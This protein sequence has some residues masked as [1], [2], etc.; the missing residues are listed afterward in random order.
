MEN[1]MCFRCDK[2]GQIIYFQKT[3]LPS[4]RYLWDATNN[5]LTSHP[6]DILQNHDISKTSSMKLLAHVL[7]LVFSTLAH[8]S[9]STM[10]D[11]LDSLQWKNRIVI[12]NENGDEKDILVL[13]EKQAAGIDDR[14][15]IWFIFKQ[16]RLITNYPG[17][18]S[19]KFLN[20]TRERY[21]TGRSKV[22]LIGKD[23][24]IKSRYDRLNLEAVFSDIDAM[25]M[26]QHEMQQ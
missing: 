18:I 8:G 9:E 21:D 26:R 10:L 1:V 16:D 20:I 19:E 25:P 2:R 11:N 17:K 4:H 22:I 5:T 24:G 13:L 7:F 15:I 6:A 23:G 3:Y 14:G 12:I